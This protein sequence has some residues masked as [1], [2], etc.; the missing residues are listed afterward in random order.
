MKKYG[1]DTACFTNSGRNTLG[2]L[3]TTLEEMK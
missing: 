1:M 2:A 3:D